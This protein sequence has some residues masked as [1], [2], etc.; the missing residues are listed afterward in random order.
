M[1]SNGC[2]LSDDDR[3][4]A[5]LLDLVAGSGEPSGR[6][7]GTDDKLDGVRGLLDDMY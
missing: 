6:P 4:G 3:D 7:S 5:V 1:Q 2:A